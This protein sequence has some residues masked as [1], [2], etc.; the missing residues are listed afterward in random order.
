[1]IILTLSV[2]LGIHRR[3]GADRFVPVYLGVTNVLP[4]ILTLFFHADRLAEFKE[5]FAYVNR[6][7]LEE[8]E[9]DFIVGK[10]DFVFVVLL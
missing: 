5:H 3:I 8:E 2:G 1:M 9:F 4:I 10:L 6:R 7:Y